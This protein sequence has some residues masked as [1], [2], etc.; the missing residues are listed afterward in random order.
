MK[1]I[2]IKRKKGCGSV[3]AWEDDGEIYIREK[4]D[5]GRDVQTVALSPIELRKILSRYE[6]G[7]SDS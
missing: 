4:L 5:R 2:T 6:E 3:V 7:G 1:A